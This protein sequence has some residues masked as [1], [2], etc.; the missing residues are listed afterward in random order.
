[1][2][3]R[4]FPVFLAAEA[5]LCLLLYWAVE[6]Q[7]QWFSTA[8]AFPL[9]QLGKGLQ[10]LSLSGEVGNDV[11]IVLYLLLSLLPL[12]AF[13]Y[14]K[15]RRALQ[16]E[17]GLLFLL[18]IFLFAALYWMVN[19]G[20]IPAYAGLKN[21]EAEKSVLGGCVYAIL[22]SYGILR[23]LRY[24]RKAD[25]NG[26]QHCLGLLLRVLAVLFIFCA[27]GAEFGAF[28]DKVEVI[29]A[30]NQGN[31]RLLGPSY[32]FLFL[33]Y[34]TSAL[35]YVLDA[36]VIFAGIALIKTLETDRYSEETVQAAHKLSKL[37]VNCLAAI[38]LVSLAFD[39][40]QVVFMESISNI[41]ITIQLPILSIAFV[42]FALLLAQFI[43]E[44]KQLK[45][46]NDL[47][48]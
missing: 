31:E 27:F 44:N 23:F 12:F 42:L 30:S 40:L 33:G 32:V 38:V 10:V 43:G 19:P 39:L 4:R 9:E 22:A 25:R 35:P 45:E 13:Y 5:V 3:T 2:K 20:L 6:A 41:S 17:D 21:M 18:S 46:D 34:L 29:R 28:L 47:F 26:L 24:F 36:A 48:I 8:L 7:P 15:C 37:C 11:A 16:A 1:M 14:I